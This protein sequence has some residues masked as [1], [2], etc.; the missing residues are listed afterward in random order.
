MEKK[1]LSTEMRVLL[2]FAISFLILILSQPLLVRRSATPPPKPLSESSPT[3]GQSQSSAE[4]QVVT[5]SALPASPK[6]GESEEEITIEGDLYR[7]V[8]STRGAVVKSWTLQRYRDQQNNPLELVNPDATQFGNPL[9]LWVAEEPLRQEINNALYVPSATGHLSAP[10][11]LTFEYSSGQTAVRKQIAFTPDSY[12]VEVTT[13][14]ASNGKAASHALAWRGGFGDMHDAAAQGYQLDVFYRAEKV[15]RLNTGSLKSEESVSSGPFP[16]AG[17]EDRFFCVAFLPPEGMLRVTSFRHEIL[18]PEQKNRLSLGVAV[19]SGDAPQNY[20]RLFVGPKEIDVLS[21]A[22]PRL[23]ELVDYGWFAFVAKPMFL[24]LRWIHDHIVTNYGWSIVLLTVAINFLLFPLKIKSLRSAMKMQK[25][26]PQL[27]A[28]QDKYKHLK[29]K[30]P[31]KQEMSRETMELYKKHGVNPIGG[32]LPML[33]QI[34]FLYGFYK[35]LIVS[36]EMRQAP[37]IWWVR[38]LSAP[39]SIPI[40]VLP[41][42]MCGTQF[43]LQKMSPA[44]TPDPRQ[45]RIMML[46]P[47]MFL[48]FFWNLSS[49]LVLYWLTGNVVGI[50]QQWYINRTEMKH[51][52]EE[53]KK[54]ASRKKVL[55]KK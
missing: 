30:D 28:I 35:V 40:K 31:K 22:D 46:M 19:G 14:V 43:I 48:F 18:V 15:I 13:E 1:E 23:A 34:P 21:Q 24:A 25:L 11:T 38:D 7:V 20:F 33:L 9:S 42:L 44:T 29:M 51:L 39:E 41:L 10:V 12:V 17:I 32:C 53:R 55:A 3:Q 45:Q 26:Q 52:I 27:K 50:A 47:L 6:Q 16:F 8:F 49:G 54:T 36:I 4:K 5:P 37:W 2:A